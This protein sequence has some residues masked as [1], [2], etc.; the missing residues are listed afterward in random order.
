MLDELD[1]FNLLFQQRP[2]SF[3]QQFWTCLI[4][5]AFTPTLL[6]VLTLQKRH[7]SYFTLQGAHTNFNS[8]LGQ[9]LAVHV[10]N[11]K[12]LLKQRSGCDQESSIGEITHHARDEQGTRR[13]GDWVKWVRKRYQK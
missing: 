6:L 12:A 5:W 1:W 9:E 4:K 13:A 10:D 7:C 2:T 8:K 3:D 11:S